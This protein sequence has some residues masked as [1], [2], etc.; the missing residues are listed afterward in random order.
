MAKEYKLA[1]SKGVTYGRQAE[2]F[3]RLNIGCPRSILENGVML[4]NK[5]YKDRRHVT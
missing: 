4:I 1:L 2:G 5:L 3:M